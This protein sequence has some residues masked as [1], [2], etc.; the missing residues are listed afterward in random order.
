MK[1]YTNL[2]KDYGYD[3]TAI[4][5]RL[6][7]IW[8][9]IFVG[10]NKVYF[11][12]E[13]M[14]YLVDTG[15]DDVRTEGMSYGM[16]MAVQYDRKDIFDRLWRWVMRYMYM[17]DGAHAHYFAWSVAPSGEKNAHGPAPDGE[18]F[19]A[20]SLFF[21]ANRWGDGEGVLNYSHHA[22]E[23]LKY[24]IHKGT[25]FAGQPMWNPENKL[26][27]FIP[28]VEFTDPSYHV[29]HF[30]EQFAL[31]ADQRDRPFWKEAAA[32]S[33][34]Y[35]KKALHPETGLNPEYSWYD[36]SP[37]LESEHPHFFSDAYRTAMNVAIDMQWYQ[38]DAVL[39]ER[40]AKL[41]QFFSGMA[42]GAENFIYTVAG[43]NTG[44]PILHPVG[45]LATL[46]AASLANPE[47]AEARAF[48]DRFWQ[49]PLRTGVRRYY[50]NF[51]YAFAFMALS[52]N[53]RIY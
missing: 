3:E 38:Q 20:L 8:D 43:E 34:A 52:G 53:Y 47:I 7:T 15:N 22:R 4:Q 12:N 37:Q 42:P 25:E 18:E 23:L 35:L 33:R 31:Y 19:F 29:P 30:Y 26:I 39:Q 51:L 1:E 36:G 13:D 2:F 40:L 21:A 17:E 45:L 24:C 32:N 6:A 28:E 11:E 48:V 16:L 50:D 14:G 41:Q 27:K 49:E 9:E 44:E 46:A 10:P 5:Q